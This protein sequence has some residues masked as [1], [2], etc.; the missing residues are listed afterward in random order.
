MEEILWGEE[1]HTHRRHYK[2][3]PSNAK[4]IIK[5]K[6]IRR[7]KHYKFNRMTDTNAHLPAITLN[8]NYLSFPIRRHGLED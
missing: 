4:I 1:K 2:E 7:T 8:I 6:R 5:Q 3:I